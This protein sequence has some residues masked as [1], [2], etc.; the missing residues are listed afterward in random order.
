MSLNRALKTTTARTAGF[1]LI[2]LLVVIVIIGILATFATLSI[3]NRALDDRLEVESKRLE[4]TLK[5][6]L[7]EAETKGIDIGFIYTQ[8][9]Y[10]FLALDKSGL[11]A[12]YVASGPLR[13]R[14]IPAPFYL[15]L[16]IEDRPVQPA[17]DVP[18]SKKIE[19]QILLLSSGE[20][21]AFAVDIK[22]ENYDPYYH[23]QADTLG[24]FQRERRD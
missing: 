4:Q 18:D 11:W 19:P 7:E 2:E 5:L 17:S 21:T 24:K 23:I 10:Q 12:P 1:T 3:G 14:P 6:A 16:R 15:E 20:V 8:E 9:Q 22:A 13:P